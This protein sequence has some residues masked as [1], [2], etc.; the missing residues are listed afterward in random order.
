MG[1]VK[2]KSGRKS[3]DKE[4]QAKVLW[5]LSVPVLKH[6]LLSTDPELK[7]RKIE[8]ALALVNK[9]LPQ[10]H[11]LPL[12]ELNLVININTPKTE[13]EQICN[14]TS[15]FVHGYRAQIPANN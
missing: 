14:D 13:S 9:M 2:G 8:I 5:D 3:W 4:A 12:G 7:F 1:G 6:V 15:G 11:N 10:E